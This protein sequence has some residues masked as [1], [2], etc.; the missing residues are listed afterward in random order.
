MTFQLF[1]I[2]PGNGVLQP[3]NV[4]S[5]PA[6]LTLEAFPSPTVRGMVYMGDFY[7]RHSDLG[8]GS[9][10]I[11]RNGV[12]LLSYIR[13][14][15]LTRWDTGGATHC[16]G[17]T[18]DY[19]LSSGLIASQVLCSSVPDLFSDHITL[20]F[21]YSL[22]AGLSGSATRLRIAEPPIYCPIYIL[23]MAHVLSTLDISS[24][25]QLYSALVSATQDFYRLYVSRPHLQDHLTAH[26]W[27]LDARIQ[28]AKEANPTQPLTCSI[29]TNC[30]GTL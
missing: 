21:H 18:L 8:D 9:G 26:S 12:R 4:Y 15:H 27:M 10:S 13:K 28:E 14:H 23:F 30:L 29:V 24:A 19:I 20:R 17:G 1:K 16:R 6:R 25:E 11:N 3:C 7:A 2:L 22:P 5:A